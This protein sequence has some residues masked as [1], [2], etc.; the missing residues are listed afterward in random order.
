MSTAVVGHRGYPARAPENTLA[1]FE[2]AVEAGAQMVETDLRVT[3]DGVIVLVHDETLERTTNGSGRVD[4]Y[5]WRELQELDAGGGRIPSLVQA[6]DAVAVPLMLDYEAQAVIEPLLRVLADEEV[7]RRVVMVGG[8]AE[9]HRA[10]CARY[11]D[12]VV[13]LTVDWPVGADA[14]DRARSV[15]ARYINPPYPAL[16]AEWVARSRAAG[17][18]ISTWTVDGPADMD[19]VL[20]LG[21]DLMITDYPDVAC[22]RRDRA[23]G[24]DG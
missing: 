8:N 21:V 1:S 2:C 5:T 16:T 10:L 24:R 20:G 14:L 4:A 23:A 13:G 18:S 11:P 12:L 17:L 7:R 19:R 9:G 22:A 6:L 3:R 15:G